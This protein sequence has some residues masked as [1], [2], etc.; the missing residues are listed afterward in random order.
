MAAVGVNPQLH[1]AAAPNGTCAFC[2]SF[3][4]FSTLKQASVQQH[5]CWIF[6]K[7]SF[8]G[9]VIKPPLHGQMHPTA[10]IDEVGKACG[11]LLC[12]TAAFVSGRLCSP[13]IHLQWSCLLKESVQVPSSSISGHPRHRRPPPPVQTLLLFTPQRP[14]GHF[15]TLS[16]LA[17]HAQLRELW[18]GR[19]RCSPEHPVQATGTQRPSANCAPILGRN[20]IAIASPK[21]I[22]AIP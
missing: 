20:P 12:S 22:H 8:G 6:A 11:P 10:Q 13:G 7:Y 4:K 2:P 21:P 1:A 16:H 19:L 15:A 9:S 17:C 18:V 3:F 14:G 5:T